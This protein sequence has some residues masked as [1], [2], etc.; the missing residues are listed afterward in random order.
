MEFEDA[1]EMSNDGICFAIEESRDWKKRT[2]EIVGLQQTYLEESVGLENVAD[3]QVIQDAMNNLVYVMKAKVQ[4]LNDEDE[5]RGLNTRSENKGR[6]TVVF[7]EIF[8][9]QPGDNVYQ[10]LKDFK[11]AVSESQV[12]R[13]DKVKTLQKYLGGKAGIITLILTLT[14][15]YGNPL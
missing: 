8:A 15:Y 13:V 14:E 7:P 12:K 9:G 2:N 1:H 4:N 10:F 11:E 3:K 5:K 6:D